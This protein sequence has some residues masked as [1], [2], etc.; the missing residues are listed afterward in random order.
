MTGTNYKAKTK[1]NEKYNS[2]NEGKGRLV[3]N[4][5]KGKRGGRREINEL[6]D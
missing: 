3:S 5:E 2:W 4:R 1:G 6:Y